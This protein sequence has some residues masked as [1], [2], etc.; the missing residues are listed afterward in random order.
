MTGDPDSMC[1]RKR[2][3][4]YRA[5]AQ[6][7]D[8]YWETFSCVPVFPVLVPTRAHRFFEVAIRYTARSERGL[9][10]FWPY[11]LFPGFIDGVPR[12]IPQLITVIA[13]PDPNLEVEVMTK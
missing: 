12:G 11:E 5:W 8:T 1:R 6:S 9:H 4:R 13:I 3:M 2:K 10:W 7:Q